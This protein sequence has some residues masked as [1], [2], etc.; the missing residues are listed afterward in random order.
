[1]SGASVSSR[2]TVSW[3]PRDG[4]LYEEGEGLERFRREPAFYR[5]G[6]GVLN[7]KDAVAIET[8]LHTRLA[9]T[10]QGSFFEQVPPK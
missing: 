4:S 1:M 10:V 7:S 8:A 9:R 3:A 5:C 6:V 2:Q